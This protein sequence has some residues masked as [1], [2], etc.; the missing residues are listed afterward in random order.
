MLYLTCN[1]LELSHFPEG[2]F[3]HS[4][5]PAERATELISE[6]KAAGNLYATFEFGAVPSPKK[7]REFKQLLEHLNG[8]G[9]TIDAHDFF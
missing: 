4:L 2:R 9:V 7:D 5:L 6:A 1:N 3:Q 8:Y